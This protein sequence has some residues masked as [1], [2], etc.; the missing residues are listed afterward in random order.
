MAPRARALS[1]SKQRIVSSYTTKGKKPTSPA[2]A[3]TR[4]AVINWENVLVP[5]DWMVVRLGLGRSTMT[6][7]LAT[8]YS[9]SQNFPDL[10]QKFTEI[11]DRIIELLSD[12]VRSVN[13]PVFIVSEYTTAYV[14]YVCSLFFPRLT[15]ALRRSTT[16]MYVVGT[17]D[18]QLTTLELYQWKTNL[19]RTVIVE[20]FCPGLSIAD[21]TNILARPAFDKLKVVA[22]CASKVDVAATSTIRSM[23]PNAVSN[24]V[25]VK[26]DK[27]SGATQPVEASN[28]LEEFFRTI[29]YASTICQPTANHPINIVL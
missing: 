19:L 9:R 18:T 10:P 29:A 1:F 26:T 24:C 5:L 3:K 7:D 15:A 16:G 11:E 12:T 6:I 4:I 21:G 22:L 13:G 27:F 28:G 17:P 23:V 25:Q 14:E 8:I 2:P 20:H